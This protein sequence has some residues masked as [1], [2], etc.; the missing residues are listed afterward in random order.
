M[1]R[2]AV[3]S[4]WVTSYLS[5]PEDRHFFSGSMKSHSGSR[6]GDSRSFLDMISYHTF[7]LDRNAKSPKILRIEIP[8]V[9]GGF[10][11][12]IFIL[13]QARGSLSGIANSYGKSPMNCYAKIFAIFTAAYEPSYCNVSLVNYFHPLGMRMRDAVLKTLISFL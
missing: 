1:S 6:V 7:C 5:H 9:S 12:L 10:F 4:W 11:S 2:P 8:D 13:S 3:L